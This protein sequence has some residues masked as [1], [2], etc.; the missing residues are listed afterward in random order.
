MARTLNIKCM[1]HL[2]PKKDF[3]AWTFSVPM[4]EL[5]AKYGLK[6]NGQQINT[7]ARDLAIHVARLT[8]QEDTIIPAK[9]KLSYLLGLNLEDNSLAPNMA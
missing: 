4:T 8:L 6:L 2:L 1:G 3:W 7:E 5:G 9:I